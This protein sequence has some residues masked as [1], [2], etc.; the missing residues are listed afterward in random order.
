M[1]ACSYAKG[2]LKGLRERTGLAQ[3][4]KNTNGLQ[5]E[6]PS[7]VESAF[8]S[9]SSDHRRLSRAFVM[10]NALARKAKISYRQYSGIPG[11]CAA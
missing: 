11:L 3:G 6:V 2:T 1:E 5:T 7:C 9:R 4:K 10:P 8:K